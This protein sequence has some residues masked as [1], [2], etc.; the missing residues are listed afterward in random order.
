MAAVLFSITVARE[1]STPR[2]TP[3]LSI[4]GERLASGLPGAWRFTA[5]LPA[6]ARMRFE[7]SPEHGATSE[8][9]VRESGRP[10]RIVWSGTKHSGPTDVAL[11]LRAEGLVQVVLRS[12]GG[13]AGWGKAA[14][15][16]GRG[17]DPLR[18]PPGPEPVD[19][20]AGTVRR[21]LAG[22]NV[23]YVILD[24]A[25]ARHFS[26]YGYERR[27]TPEIDRIASE[28]V[29]FENARTVASFTLLAMASTWTS[30]LPDAHHN[31]VPYGAPLPKDRLT[32]AELL[33]A[34]GIHTAG[35]VSNGVAG[36]GFALDRGFAEF[37]E[38]FKRFGSYAPAYRR[39][40]PAWLDQNASRRFF[41]Y[42]HFREPH[43]AYDPPPPFD[44]LFGPDAPLTREIKTKYDWI[45]D[46]N[47]GR[48]KPTPAQ[49]E[50]LVRLYD[51]N[52]ASVDHE[53]GEVR[54]MLEAKGL[55][56]RTLVI[57]TADHGDHLY[58][59]GYV[60]HLDQVYEPALHIPLVV[61][62]PKGAGPS[63]TRVG[64]LV[65]TLD[66][67][68]TIADAFGLL[69]RGGS[70][71]AF[72]GRSLLPVALGAPGKVAVLSRCAGEQPKYALVSGSLK[73][74]YHTARDAGELYDLAADPGETNDLAAARPLEAE[75]FRQTIRRWVMG[76]REG[77]A[78]V[79]AETR[80]S[81][82]QRENLRALGYVQ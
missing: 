44:T 78:S 14:V 16:A 27:T 66:M 30:S 31:G 34:N 8:V 18:E 28:G 35:F 58:E 24:A 4:E 13:G 52:L 22:S 76:L 64:A 61:K 36:A 17:A 40:L 25:G 59:H 45:T 43:F 73:L 62:F 77:P 38:V 57:V 19:P 5:R 3:A 80:L 65:D 6:D 39:V 47:W 70:D 32:L 10:E 1:S 69:G 7:P 29:V 68:P 82:D 67:A 71:R 79:S 41:A 20:R 46:V 2:S 55:W 12:R 48:V 23:L 63:G 60:G 75:Y 11:G 21:A 51:G 33:G 50:H 53:L 54:R 15:V 72:S 42:V 56:D 37:D 26:T 9:I 81:D 49:L 74:V